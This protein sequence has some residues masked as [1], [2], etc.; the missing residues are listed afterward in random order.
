[1]M[2]SERSSVSAILVQNALDDQV[3]QSDLLHRSEPAD[4][5]RYGEFRDCLYF[6][7]QW[8]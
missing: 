2:G 5:I 7:I 6:P 1:M 8:C 4:L 3:S